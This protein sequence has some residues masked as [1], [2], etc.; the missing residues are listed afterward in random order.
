MGP[1]LYQTFQ[2]AGLPAPTMRMEM[3]LGKEPDL[4]Q[5][6]YDTL[7]SLRPQMQRLRLPVESLGSLDTLV[8][9]L[10]AEAAE[11]KTVACWFALVGAW[12]RKA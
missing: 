11:S 9:R 4:A 1:D 8:D 7:C 10:R 12:S 3:S 6:Y 2:E 5:W